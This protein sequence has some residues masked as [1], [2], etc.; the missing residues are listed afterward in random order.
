MENRKLLIIDNLVHIFWIE[1]GLL[2]LDYQCLR[3]GS[4]G[5]AHLTMFSIAVAVKIEI[6]KGAVYL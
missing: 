2:F 4:R 1:M 5:V 3:L 6:K